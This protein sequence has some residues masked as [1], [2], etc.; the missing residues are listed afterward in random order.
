MLRLPKSS[1]EI[2]ATAKRAPH[3]HVRPRTLEND[4]TFRSCLSEFSINT[5]LSDESTTP[6]SPIQSGSTNVHSISNLC[7]L[8]SVT[9]QTL[10]VALEI[11]EMP[12]K[13][14]SE[15]LLEVDLH[16][17]VFVFF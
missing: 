11:K 1:A 2:L 3:R 17:W 14:Q 16:E 5:T 4:P 15:D 8:D 7:F 6:C 9:P 12:I 13:E 10:D